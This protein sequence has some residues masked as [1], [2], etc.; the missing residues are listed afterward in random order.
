[1]KLKETVFDI[2]TNGL[3]DVLD[4]MHV[5]S[6]QTSEQESPNSGVDAK[7]IEQVFETD[8]LIG[9]FITWYDLEAIKRLYKMSPGKEVIIVDTLALAWYLDTERSKYGLES[10]GETF[11][12]K[13]PYIHDWE[14]LTQEEY[15]NRCETDVKINMRLWRRL[16][17][18]LGALYGF[19]KDGNLSKEAIRLIKYLTFKMQS[20]FN[21]SLEGIRLDYDYCTTLL[22]KLEGLKA[23]KEKELAA[24]MPKMAL[25][26]LVNKPKNLYK[27][28]KSLSSYGEKWFNTL[29]EQKL[30][31]TTQGPIR[32]VQ[33]YIEGN[34]GS[35]GQVKEW[36]YSLGWEPQTFKYNK[37]KETGEEKAVE[38]V[39]K[40][41]ELCD[42]VK[43][44]VDKD[45]A[46][47]HLDGYTVLTHRISVLKGFLDKA[48]ERD[49][50]YWL[51]F[52]IDGF[53]NTLRFKHRKPLANL[54]GVDKAYGKEVRS[55]LLAPS[56]EYELV[57]ADMVSLEDTTKRHYMY[58]FD[59]DY[60]KE[61]SV[62]GFD[63]HLDLAKYAGAC[64]QEDINLYNEGKKPEL[65][66]IRKN[67]KAA[68]YSCVYGVGAPKLSR[69][70]GIKQ[71]E[72]KELIEAYWKRNY[73]VKRV[74]E[75]QKTK[76]LRDGSLWVYN[77]VS[78][79]WMSLR[80]MKD[81]FSTLN[82]S[83]GVFVF[84]SW[85]ALV[86]S[87]GM[88]VI[89]QYHDE[90][91]GYIKKGCREESDRINTNAIN[92]LNERI[93]LNIEIKSDV[94]YGNNYAE[95]H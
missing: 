95:V 79:F 86:I 23:I 76:T 48:E 16:R 70:L 60:V 61:M 92:K 62:D 6:W 46:I 91:L 27:K 12:V 72:A 36:L 66:S 81:I 83:T 69:S 54:P 18:K 85:L 44:L 80:Y 15:T 75:T 40:D 24:A 34:P 9:H 31:L 88:P 22:A 32:V 93:Q 64:S 94:N 4:R 63:P 29:R 84:D 49:G 39:R 13:K 30:P 8:L 58:Y 5:I 87:E 82:Q 14:N 57:G 2:E 90:Y 26:K 78:G 35:S 73:S 43:A 17:N 33:E 21:H 59:P 77:P 25:T 50:Q 52:E 20:A 7:A 55:C 51:K 53:T 45:P 28:D 37:N 47:E 1:M 74:A 68:N 67:F 41:G 42:S 10:Y 89:M 38:Q 11:G 3:F 71:S 65:K 56:E 19:D